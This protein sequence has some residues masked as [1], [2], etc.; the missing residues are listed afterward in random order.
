M[1]GGLAL[2]QFSSMVD[3]HVF[4]G[5]IVRFWVI[6]NDGGNSF[7]GIQDSSKIWRTSGVI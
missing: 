5:F 4:T 2:D 7:E 1:D 6:F 3:N